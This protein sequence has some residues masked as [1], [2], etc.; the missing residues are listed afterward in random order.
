MKQLL[1]PIACLLV[2]ASVA[3]SAE[4]YHLTFSDTSNFRLTT[5]MD[6]K[7]PKFF[8]IISTTQTWDG[9]RFW[10]KDFDN[11]QK[12]AVVQQIQ[13][14]EHHPYFH[15]YLFA[16]QTLDA[17][18]PDSTK[19]QLRNKSQTFKRKKISLSGRNFKTI[20]S[21]ST[22]T[23]FYFVTSE[24]LISDD[25][26]FAFID[27]TVFYKENIQQALNETYFGSIAL[28]F[29]KIDGKWIRIAKEDWLIL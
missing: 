9:N 5:L 23:G 28:V 3:Q 22:L 1:I 18:I 11:K 8:F 13:H 6:R 21:S 25:K 7:M 20:S 26:R 12:N 19:Q 10:L 27:M 17:L 4:I 15:S 24:P 29:Q 16:N 14:D 2:Y